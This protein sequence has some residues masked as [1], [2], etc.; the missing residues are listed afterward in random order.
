MSTDIDNN[1]PN[2]KGYKRKLAC[3]DR[4]FDLITKNCITEYK[5]HHPDRKGSHITQ[6]EILSIMGEC[7]LQMLHHKIILKIIKKMRK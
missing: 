4:V 5:N 3:S 6:N 2:E 7:F 1:Y